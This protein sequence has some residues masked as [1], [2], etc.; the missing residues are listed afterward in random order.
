MPRHHHRA[1]EASTAW[2]DQKLLPWHD[3]QSDGEN[4][5]KE[6]RLVSYRQWI[7]SNT[8]THSE[9]SYQGFFNDRRYRMF[10]Q[11]NWKTTC[12]TL[13]NKHFPQETVERRR[14]ELPTSALRTP[15]S[16]S[17]ATAPKAGIGL[18][19]LVSFASWSYEP[20]GW[21]SSGGYDGLQYE[22]FSYLFL[23]D[24]F[25]THASPSNHCPWC[26]RTQSSWCHR[27][28]PT[29]SLGLPFRC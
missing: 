29:R 25:S 3:Q 16:P 10:C 14:L 21:V 18:L 17:W 6:Q 27:R 28:P 23:E 5:K 2:M 11:I 20:S 12:N 4:A 7:I 1:R 26:Q 24:C 9:P 15:R 22:G 13:Q 8:A 19:S